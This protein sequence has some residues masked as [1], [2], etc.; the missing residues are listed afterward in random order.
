MDDDIDLFQ[1]TICE[2]RMTSDIAV[3]E[4]YLSTAFVTKMKQDVRTTFADKLS[5]IG[6]NKLM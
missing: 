6:K 3:V 1:S 5:N 4:I 2:R